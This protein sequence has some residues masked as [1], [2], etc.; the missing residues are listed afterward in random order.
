M[1]CKIRILQRNK[2]LTS[3]RSAGITPP[4]NNWTTSS[5]KICLTADDNRC[6]R[7]W[8]VLRV[9]LHDPRLLHWALNG[10]IVRSVNPYYRFKMLQPHT[11]VNI[12][13]CMYVWVHII[14]T[15]YMNK[16]KVLFIILLTI[17]YPTCGNYNIL[18]VILLLISAI[19]TANA[20]LC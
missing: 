18:P 14:L 19:S 3:R 20:W 12:D 7:W 2:F 8:Q 6:H 1:T 13:I 4:P 17:A 15:F 10:S 11:H 5:R 9:C 16:T